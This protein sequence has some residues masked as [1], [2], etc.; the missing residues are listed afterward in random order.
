MTCREQVS[1]ELFLFLRQEVLVSFSQ[2]CRS[3]E[4]I[5]KG[6]EEER[7]SKKE[8]NKNWK[9]MSEDMKQNF[10]LL[11]HSNVAALREWLNDQ[12]VA[13]KDLELQKEI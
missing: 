12:G 6:L 5:T 2:G 11:G 3:G 1:Y 9:F 8:F 10:L 7:K 13:V 4:A